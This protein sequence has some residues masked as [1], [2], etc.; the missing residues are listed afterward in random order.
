M[1]GRSFRDALQ[2]AVSAFVLMGTDDTRQVMT[3]AFTNYITWLGTRQDFSTAVQ[4]MDAVKAS[5][6]GIVNMDEPRREM[7][8]NWIVSLLDSRAFSDADALLAQPSTRA[9]LDDADWTAL[10][11]AVV[12]RL[13]QAEGDNGGSIAAAGVVAD[14]LKRLGRQPALLQTYEAYVHNA[15]AMLFN[16]RKPAD[17]K[18]LVDQGLAVYPDSRMLQQDLDLARK[19]M[20][21]NRS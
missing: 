18:A 8:H 21:D 14:A 6:G 16:A 7:Y 3:I 10:S 13:A 1:D 4:F 5:F 9:A 11:V 15:F 12:Q 17:A 19:A 2:P 20:R